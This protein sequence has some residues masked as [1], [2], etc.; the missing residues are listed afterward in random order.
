MYKYVVE[1]G[2]LWYLHNS[3]LRIAHHYQIMD[4]L[5]HLSRDFRG[6][7]YTSVYKN[8]KYRKVIFGTNP[9]QIA[10]GAKCP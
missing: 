7:L 8:V 4:N 9:V 3:K 5:V 2:Y 6:G 1:Q 10:V